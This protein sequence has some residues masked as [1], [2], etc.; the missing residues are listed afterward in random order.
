MAQF[1]VYRNPNPRTRLTFP[2]IVDIQSPLLSELTTRVVIPLG[3]IVDFHGDKITRLTPEIEFENE[4]LLLLTPQMASIPT[5]VLKHAIGTLK[6]M[7]AEIISAIDFT[8]SE[9]E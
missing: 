5:R 7:R 4:K 9:R 8:I 2:F 3:R 6:Q 1:D